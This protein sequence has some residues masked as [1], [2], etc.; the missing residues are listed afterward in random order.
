[1]RNAARR[2]SIVI[3]ALAGAGGA[4]LAGC[5]GSLDDPDRFRDGGA[6]VD[7]ACFDPPVDLFPQ[8][9]GTSGCHNASM[10]AQGLDLVSADVASRLVG[11]MSTE[12]AG[13]LADPNDARASMLV[14]KL[15]GDPPCGARMP[16]VG[17]KLGD[18]EIDCVVAWIATL[19]A[20][21][22]GGGGTVTGSGGGGS[23][24]AG[25][26]GGSGGSAGG[27]H[28]GGGGP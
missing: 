13:V 4:L 20:R 7:A 18:E 10:P 21:G 3:A 15:G 14:R 25:G 12:C 8:R 5:P 22:S 6:T 26:H 11:V 23:G 1:M 27:G 16:L 24:G 2:I 17:D 9:C 19:P 28:G